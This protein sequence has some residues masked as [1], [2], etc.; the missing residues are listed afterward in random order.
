MAEN[1]TVEQIVDALREEA[2]GDG[3]VSVGDVLDRIGK[4]GFGPLMLIPALV[5]VTPIGGIPT[6]PTLFAMTV[7]LL[8]LQVIFGRRSLWLPRVIRDRALARKR[9]MQATDKARPVARR[10][11]GLFGKRFEALTRPPAPRVA[12]GLAL[13]LCLTIPPLEFIPFAALLPVSGIALLGLAITLRDGLVMALAWIIS[14][15]GLIGGAWLM[16]SG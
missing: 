9:L 14:I 8:A 6:V 11:D 3:D 12:A 4:R 1:E 15:L 7:A 10:L 13:M 16:I 2:S 5:V